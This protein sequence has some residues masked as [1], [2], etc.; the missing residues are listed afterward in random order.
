MVTSTPEPARRTAPTGASKRISA[1]ASTAWS[2]QASSVRSASHPAPVGLMEHRPVES[3]PG[4]S[5][6]CLARRQH[7]GTHRPPP[8]T[9]LPP[10][11]ARRRRRD[12][13]PRSRPAGAARH[14]PAGDAS[15]PTIPA[16]ASRT[17]GRCSRIGRSAPPRATSRDRDLGRSG[18]RA[19]P[20]CLCE[21][22]PTSSR[23][24]PSPH[25]S[26]RHQASRQS[27]PHRG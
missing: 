17:P 26:P 1:P 22:V 10:R 18:R 3:H 14:P 23:P 25:R 4:P 21:P 16:P 5:R 20:T 11:R 6:R 15:R 13:R 19:T 12:R 2:Q 9:P 27:A 7:L 8:H 24:P